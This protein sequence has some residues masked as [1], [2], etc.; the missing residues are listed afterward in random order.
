MAKVAV[1][2]Q[3][4]IIQLLKDSQSGSQSLV[5]WRW[6]AFSQSLLQDPDFQAV[7]GG[8]LAVG[9]DEIARIV[10]DGL[11]KMVPSLEIYDKIAGGAN[12]IIGYA[13]LAVTIATLHSQDSYFLSPSGKV[14]SLL[15]KPASRK[16]TAEGPSPVDT[17]KAFFAALEAGNTG[18]ANS[19]LYTDNRGVKALTWGTIGLSNLVGRFVFDAMSYDEQ[20][21]DGKDASVAVSGTMTYADKLGVGSGC[22]RIDGISRLAV[23]DGAWKIK[24]LPVYSG[25]IRPVPVEPPKISVPQIPVTIPSLPSIP[26]V[27]LPI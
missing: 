23:Q 14:D 1:K 16:E 10:A 9:K 11:V 3:S 26:K 25:E 2:H 19:Y 13:A 17:L 4:D 21:N 15:S 24:L 22:F 6:A 7:L 5:A 18:E 12:L 8:A 27:K 20:S